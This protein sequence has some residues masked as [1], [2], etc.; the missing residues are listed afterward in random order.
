MSIF[1]TV[2]VFFVSVWGWIK[3]PFQTP[4]DENKALIKTL[5][6]RKAKLYNKAHKLPSS[7]KKPT[8]KRSSK[9]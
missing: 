7:K 6:T 2:I 5:K 1:N 9:T 3:F 4:V 8:A